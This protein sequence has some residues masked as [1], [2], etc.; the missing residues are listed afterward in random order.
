MFRTKYSMMDGEGV[1]WCDEAR[2]IKEIVR[3]FSGAK[4]YVI[5]VENGK[6]RSLTDKEEVE[7]Q[8]ELAK[9]RSRWRCWLASICG[10][11]SSGLDT[12]T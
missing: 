1:G 4:Q 8:S 7:L 5:A 11:C 6:P 3:H 2:T 12:P 10:R 9:Q